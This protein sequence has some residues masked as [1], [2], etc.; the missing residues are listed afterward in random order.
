[1]LWTCT[2]TFAEC[3]FSNTN[4]LGGG[5]TREEGGQGI[6]T[7]SHQAC[8]QECQKRPKCNYWTFVEAWKVN[9][10]LNFR[11]DEKVDFDGAISG[12]FGES[13]GMRTKPLSDFCSETCWFLFQIN[14]SQTTKNLSQKTAV[15]LTSLSST[16]RSRPLL[17]TGTT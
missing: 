10:Y 13:C 5:L 4:L 9:C 3:Q 12:A 17:T 2:V 6:E 15:S 16:P 14:F 1:M 8:S 11:L 7:A